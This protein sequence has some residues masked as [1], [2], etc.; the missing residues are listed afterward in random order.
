MGQLFVKS[1]LS[2]VQHK[3]IEA[4]RSGKFTFNHRLVHVNLTLFWLLK[5][6]ALVTLHADIQGSGSMLYFKLSLNS[7]F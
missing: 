1:I 6:D 7:L 4:F 5:I 3:H 2:L